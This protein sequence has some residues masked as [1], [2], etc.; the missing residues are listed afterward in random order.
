[1]SRLGL[2]PSQTV[3]PYLSLALRRPDSQYVVPAGTPGAC[4]IRGR[5]LDGRG[6]VVTDALV[7]TWQADV[8]GI[9][10]HPR[11]ERY[12]GVAITPGFRGFGRSETV[13]GGWAI[14]TVRPGRA[15]GAPH[16]AV[17]VFARGLLDRLVTRIYLPDQDNSGDPVLAGLDPARAATLVAAPA[18]DGYHL[19][20]T[21]QGGHET[22]FFAV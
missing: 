22:V 1:M 3:G 14:H 21:L 15:D 6:E 10:C 12:A 19:D 8:D 2:T 9:Y 11:D 17:S 13:A 5:V 16:L 18:E 20:I 7:E 4:W